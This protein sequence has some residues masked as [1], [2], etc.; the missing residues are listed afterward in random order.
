MAGLLSKALAIQASVWTH[1]KVEISACLYWKMGNGYLRII[2]NSEF[3][4]KLAFREQERCV[5]IHVHTHA[6]TPKE[7]ES[8]DSG[9]FRSFL[10][11]SDNR[12]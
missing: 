6:E 7:K 2:R 8:K 4:G 9:I 11:S 1:V 12:K 5:C 3:G 10:D